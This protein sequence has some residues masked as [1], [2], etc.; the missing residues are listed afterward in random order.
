MGQALNEGDQ[1]KKKDLPGRAKP[2]SLALSRS[3][4][5][6]TAADL[7]SRFRNRFLVGQGPPLLHMEECFII[8]F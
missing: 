7:V 2:R 3:L 4:Q 8:R 6:A 5:A 1:E